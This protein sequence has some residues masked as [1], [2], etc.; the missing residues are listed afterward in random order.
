MLQ[1]CQPVGK[2][3]DGGSGSPGRPQAEPQVVLVQGSAQ[4]AT[5]LVRGVSSM[6]PQ[7]VATCQVEVLLASFA[8]CSCA[9]CRQSMACCPACHGLTPWRHSPRTIMVHVARMTSG[10]CQTV[11]PQFHRIF[12]SDGWAKPASESLDAGHEALGGE[13]WGGDEGRSAVRVAPI[14]R[15]KSAQGPKS[16]AGFLATSPNPHPITFRNPL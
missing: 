8:G 10:C 7:L 12:A 16:P 1:C 13:R 5:L 2:A 11:R 15:Q 14:C 3:D 9:C 4:G 6:L